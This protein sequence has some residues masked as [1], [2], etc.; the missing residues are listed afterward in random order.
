M[1][2]LPVRA[3]NILLIC[4]FILLASGTANA[5][6]AFD[7]RVEIPPAI[8]ARDGGFFLGEYANIT[9]EQGFVDSASMVW[10]EPVDGQFDMGDVIKALGASEAAGKS[11]ALSMP[12][13]V[14]VVKESSVAAELRAMTA[15]K[16]RIDVERIDDGELDRY[17]GYSLPPKVQPGARSVTV[18]LIDDDGRKVSRQIKLRWFQPVVYS[19]KAL[20][21]G[22]VVNRSDL[23]MRVGEIGMTGTYAWL[24]EQVVNASLRQSIGP[25]RPI[26]AGDV[27][28]PDLVR[29]GSSVTLIARVNGLGIETHGIAMQRGGI[30]DVIK[31]KNLSSKKVL[32]G[33]I[34]DAGTVL[35]SR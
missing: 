3:W 1:S 22:S 32:S 8:E 21:R 12:E 25:G 10:I 7:L 20:H 16:W 17:A 23:R 34:I 29:P 19:T 26:A 11:V 13:S 14:K 35:I 2:K 15:W 5:E 4:L 24:P 30:G 27:T 33:K 28:R 9:G 6:E 18:K 31:V